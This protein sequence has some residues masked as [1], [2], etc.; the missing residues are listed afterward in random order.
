MDTTAVL[1]AYRRRWQNAYVER[2]F[3]SVRTECL[4]HVIV[5]NEAYLRRVLKDYFKYC[6]HDRTHLG[7]E[8]D[9]P[10]KQL[11]PETTGLGFRIIARPR[12]GGLRHR[13]EC[14][15]AA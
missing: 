15:K 3:G 4:D 1:T 7:L 9:T 13:Y 8:K 2:L 5:W 11:V 6:H 10:A 14:S 12:A